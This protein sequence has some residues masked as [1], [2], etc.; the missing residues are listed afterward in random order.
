MQMNARTSKIAAVAVGLAALAGTAV[1]ATTASAVSPTEPLAPPGDYN[2]SMQL[3]VYNVEDW[4]IEV[5]PDYPANHCSDEW[6]KFDK[7]LA[8][9][10]IFDLGY[11]ATTSG[12]CAIQ[13]SKGHWKVR[14]F[15]TDHNAHGSYEVWL[16][17]GR[18]GLYWI[19]L[20]G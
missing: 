4:S 1:V 2:V 5:T 17:E 19:T 11:K 6:T 13:D 12:S 7:P 14:L 18:M 10:N 16:D 15:D 9:N 20:R 3:K 8:D